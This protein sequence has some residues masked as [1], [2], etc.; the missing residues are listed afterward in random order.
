MPQPEILD[1]DT[2]YTVLHNEVYA[3]VFL[4]KLARDYKIEPQ[5]REQAQ[6]MFTQAAQLRAAHDRSL[7]SQGNDMDS[8]LSK[9]AAHLNQRLGG[10]PAAQQ[11]DA[12]VKQAAADVA[13][14]ADIAKA[15]L[16]MHALAAQNNAA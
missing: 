11:N 12:M 5:T 4:T 15:V 14:R 16:S 8:L 13:K 10:Q 6:A 1:E 9:S 7:Q 3:P 2:A